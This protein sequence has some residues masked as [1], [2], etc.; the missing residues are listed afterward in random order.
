MI[1]WCIPLIV[2]FEVLGGQ[3]SKLFR[4][5]GIP[6]SLA[7]VYAIWHNH[8]FSYIW[9]SLIYA[10]VLNLGYGE[11][12]KL[13]KWLGSEQMVRIVYGCLLGLPVVITS[14]LTMNWLALLGFPLIVAACCIRLGSWGKIGRFD[15]L[16]VDILRGLAIGLAMSF[17]LI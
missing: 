8:P 15:I 7:I 1:F 9:P 4:P 14:A 5:I 6:L 17:A 13:Y 12:S 11:N 3:I 16:P 2:L 10:I